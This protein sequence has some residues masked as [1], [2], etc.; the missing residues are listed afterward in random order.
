[1]KYC[2]FIRDAK[3][4][5]E[6]IF[7][8]TFAKLFLRELKNSNICFNNELKN[9]IDNLDNIIIGRH[10][11]FE[12]Q[13]LFEYISTICGASEKAVVLIVDEVDSATNNKVV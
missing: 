7:S 3:F 5:N 8:F 9:I 1:M 10:E 13:E 11:D 4:R 12:L 6:N 2:F